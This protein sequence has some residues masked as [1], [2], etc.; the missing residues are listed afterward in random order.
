MK[1]LLE[2]TRKINKLLQKSEKVAYD[3][4]SILLSTVIG[5]NIYIVSKD[6]TLF[7]YALLDNFECDLMR[8]NVLLKER[9]PEHYV[10][11]LLRINETSP[12]LSLDGGIC[13]FSDGTPCLFNDKFTTIVPIHGVGERIGT[14]IRSPT[15]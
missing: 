11:W 14:L 4:M 12:N 13:A 6:G 3:E 8:D 7:G 10:E 2:R 5:A 1:S 15:P 9:F